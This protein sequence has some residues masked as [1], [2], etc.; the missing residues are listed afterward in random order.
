MRPC[1]AGLAGRCRCGGNSWRR[2]VRRSCWSWS[3][4]WPGRP[5]IRRRGGRERRRGGGRGD[6][7]ES[8]GAARKHLA[9]G[10]GGREEA[11]AVVH[12]DSGGCHWNL[13]HWG[14]FVEDSL[15]RV[16]GLW[17]VSGWSVARV[18]T[19]HGGHGEIRRS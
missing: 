3:G 2:C 9:A 13:Q 17:V 19:E 7:A 16:M 15:E 18:T 8:G 6:G 10:E 5:R 12:E 4:R 1:W 11:A 14:G